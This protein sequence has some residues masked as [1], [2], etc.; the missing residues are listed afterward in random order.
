VRELIVATVGA[1][2]LIVLGLATVNASERE[3]GGHTSA[4]E[5]DSM[6]ASAAL[7]LAD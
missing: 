7:K 6:T 4:A 5:E 3:R 2:T 1:M